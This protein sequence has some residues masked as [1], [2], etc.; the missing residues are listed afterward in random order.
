MKTRRSGNFRASG[1]RPEGSAK[2]T[3]E[4][5]RDLNYWYGFASNDGVV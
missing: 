4:R 2:C 5:E 1:M 3:G